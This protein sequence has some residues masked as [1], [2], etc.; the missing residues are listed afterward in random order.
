MA[1]DGGGNGGYG[2][3]GGK[4]GGRGDDSCGQMSAVARYRSQPLLA[5]P[6]GFLICVQGAIVSHRQRPARLPPALPYETC[7]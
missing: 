1:G 2:G 4:A 5:A 3:D 6:G 7:R